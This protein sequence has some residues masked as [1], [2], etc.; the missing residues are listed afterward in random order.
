MVFKS[1]NTRFKNLPALASGVSLT[2]S[3]RINPNTTF[4]FKRILYKLNWLYVDMFQEV[5]M[6]IAVYAISKNEEKFVQTFL[7][8]AQG[9]DYIVVADTGSTDRTVELLKAGGAIVHNITVTPWRFDDARNASLALVPADADVCICLDLD[10]VLVGRWAEEL[11]TRWQAGT[12]ARGRYH[13]VWSWD[14]WGKPAVQFYGDKIH[15][16]HGFRWRLPC[17]EVLSFYAPHYVGTPQER[18]PT[19][20]NVLWLEEL[21]IHHHPDPTKSRSQYLHLLAMAAAEAPND[22]RTAHYYARELMFNQRWEEAIAEFKRHL[23]LPTAQWD[24]ERAASYRFIARCLW[25]LRR[26][27]EAEEM[28]HKAVEEAPNEREPWVELAQAKRAHK[29]YTGVLW[30]VERA[31]AIQSRPNS[32]ISDPNAWSDWPEKMREEAMAIL[33][34]NANSA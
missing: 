23:S 7:K 22:D 3:L 31:L 19:V 2:K 5:P 9:A 17:H 16:R 4:P 11:R 28:L 27:H 25:E 6:K 14:S 12:H 15:A 26:T 1:F 24:A 30:A 18:A 33:N 20:E 13:Y 21:R 34:E 29:N 10:E 32:Y 8:S